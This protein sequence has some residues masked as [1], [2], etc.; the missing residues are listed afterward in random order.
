M[1]RAEPVIAFGSRGNERAQSV[2]SVQKKR[3]HLARDGELMLA[4]SLEQVFHDMREARQFRK[5]QS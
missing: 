3:D 5:I 1:R 2:D 4:Q